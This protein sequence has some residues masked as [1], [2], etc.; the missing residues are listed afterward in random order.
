MAPY[1]SR[2]PAPSSASLSVR[3]YGAV[4][5]GVTD[6][7]DAIAAAIAAA[8]KASVA[9]SCGQGCGMTG[10]ELRF[11]VG[12]YIVSR[13]LSPASWM[14]GEAGAMIQS[15]NGSADVFASLEIWRL[16][17]QGLLIHGG[18]HHFNLG[19]NDTDCSFF[20]FRDMTFSNASGAAIRIRPASDLPP[21]Y[22]GSSSTQVT[23]RD[24][25]FFNNEQVTIFHGD[26]ITIEDVWVEGCGYNRSAFKALFENFSKMIL[27]RMLGVPFT[28]KGIGQR[29][30]DNYGCAAHNTICTPILAVSV[31]ARTEW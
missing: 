24:S 20:D 21:F 25:K 14:R 13:T 23:V 26:T 28:H 31:L 6:D 16:T 9:H 18:R 22:R 11:P 4:G 27:N 10:P 12:K 17:V 5:D 15:I 2:P 7:T 19:T 3:D 30:A 29:W 8:S 1:A